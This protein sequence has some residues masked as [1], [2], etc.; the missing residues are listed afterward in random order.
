MRSRWS[1]ALVWGVE[2]DTEWRALGVAIGHARAD[3]MLQHYTPLLR[4]PPPCMPRSSWVPS[5]PCASPCQDI[6]KPI[7]HA[8]YEPRTAPSASTSHASTYHTESS[9]MY[10]Q[11]P[12]PSCPMPSSPCPML[13]S[14]CAIHVGESCVDCTLFYTWLHTVPCVEVP[15]MRATPTEPAC[16]HHAGINVR[17]G[18]ALRGK[19]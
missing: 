15:V 18:I 5:L 7:Q 14:P 9:S 4:M 11:S 19:S 17:M 6:A 2:F 10:T 13:P 3:S 1:L 12:H 8:L 16:V